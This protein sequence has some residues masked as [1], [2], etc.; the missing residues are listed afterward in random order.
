MVFTMQSLIPIEQTFDALY[1]LEILSHGPQ[2]ARAQVVVRD[3]VKQPMGLVHG[4]VYASIAESLTSMATAQAVYPDG[5]SAQGLSNQTSF[6]RPIFE[7][8]IHAVARRRHRGRTTWVWEVEIT[9]DEDRLC[10]LVRMTIA[11]RELPDT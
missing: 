1:G 6:L 10:A 11:V 4:G 7:G 5:M 8:T 3:A 9:D 2:E